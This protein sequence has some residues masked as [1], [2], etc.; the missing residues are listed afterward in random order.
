MVDHHSLRRICFNAGML[1][2]CIEICSLQEFCISYKNAITRNSKCKF[3]FVR[4]LIE[5]SCNDSQRCSFP[6]S[7]WL[8]VH[9]SESGLK[10]H[11]SLAL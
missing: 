10:V 4:N 8:Q 5:I 3:E 2:L 6:L 7:V 1:R 11:V 9:E